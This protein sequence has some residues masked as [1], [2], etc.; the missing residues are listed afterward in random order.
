MIMHVQQ[1]GTLT[2]ANGY[3]VRFTPDQIYEMRRAITG[4]SLISGERAKDEVLRALGPVS[5]EKIEFERIIQKDSP[6]LVYAVSVATHNPLGAWRYLVDAQT[7]KVL[8]SEEPDAST[9]AGIDSAMASGT[10]ASSMT[11]RSLLSSFAAAPALS[12]LTASAAGARLPIRKG[13]LLGMLPKTLGYDD[14]FKLAKECGFESVE[15]GTVEDEREA[16]QIKKAA[17]GAGLPIHSVMNQ[18]HWKFPLS[19]ADPQVVAQSVK[20][21]ETS[22]RNA[23]L[24]GAET[25][26]LVP[27]VVNAETS[28]QDAWTRSQ[29][30]IRKMIPMAERFEDHHRGGRGLEQVPAQSHRVCAL[31]G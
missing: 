15:C 28:Y 13:V 21:M 20:G 10:I 14:R 8:G 17:D 26:L 24:W 22:L 31:R 30:E 23:K 18:A 12:S 6:N 27:A 1:D 7:G 3:L 4:S 2:A 25:V 19:S 29:R 16:E 5:I 11:R 9:S